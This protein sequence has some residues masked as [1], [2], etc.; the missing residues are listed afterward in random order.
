MKERKFEMKK[1]EKKPTHLRKRLR[2]AMQRI[3][4]LM[5]IYRETEAQNEKKSKG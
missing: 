2:G 1:T 3:D 5:K 4:I